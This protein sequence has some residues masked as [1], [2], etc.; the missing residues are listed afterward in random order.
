MS[1]RTALI[2]A[3]LSLLAAL[4]LSAC[5]GSE[6]AAT[7]PAADPAPDPAAPSGPAYGV[8]YVD[9]GGLKLT[10]LHTGTTTAL[11]LGRLEVQTYAASADA[12]R[13]AVAV[14]TGDSVRLALV[15]TRTATLQPLHAAA[16][17]TVYSLAWSPDGPGL[18]FGFYAG[19]PPSGDERTG[20]GGIRLAD[21]RGG[22]IR[23]AGCSS[24][25]IVHRWLPDGRLAVSDGR[26][27]YVVERDGCATRS[28]VDARRM[29]ELTIAPDGRR[30]AYLHRELRYDAGRRAYVPDST[31][32]L[33]G[34][35]GSEA[36]EVAG[37]RY[38]A[39]RPAW[40]P[41]ATV[42]AFDVAA[43]E[44]PGRLVSLYDR[45][46][47]QATY[48][49]PP[50]P[51]HTASDVRPLW[52]PGGTRLAFTRREGETAHPMVYTFTDLLLRAVSTG[53]L[54]QPALVGWAG[55][56]A[57]LL[58]D[59]DGAAVLAPVQGPAV[60]LPTARTL[61]H[62]WPVEPAARP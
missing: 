9:D 16:R 35:D 56:D 42:L 43:P 39:H 17:G 41:D 10:N 52:S 25:T 31:L 33:A 5:A 24:S 61:L 60:P 13:V 1:P 46:T 54:R 29:H 14:A 47:Q 12:R 7:P 49:V 48:L 36:V 51:G 38:R 37:D 21:A 57:L 11:A 3:T 34:L 8:L 23:D 53:T 32:M 2:P 22:G 50:D 40:S 62:G 19:P 26:N 6:P 44:G 28:T 27:L 15:D 4:L 18:A 20:P 59:P 58:Q 30:M 55:D 45:D